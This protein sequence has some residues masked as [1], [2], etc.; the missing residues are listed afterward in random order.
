[1]DINPSLRLSFSNI[2]LHL[3]KLEQ[4]AIRSHQKKL[5]LFT[6]MSE[7]FQALEKMGLRQ[8]HQ[9]SGCLQCTVIAQVLISCGE[10]FHVRDLGLNETI[11][12]DPEEKLRE[13]VHLVRFEM[14]VSMDAETGVSTLGHWQITDWD[15]LLDGNIFYQ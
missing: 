10:I 7:I 6:L 15:D 8:V 14:V 9:T 5:S 12:G 4:E 1:V 13:V 2:Y 11:Q 3:D